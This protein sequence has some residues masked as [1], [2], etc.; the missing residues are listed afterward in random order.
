[1]R[2]GVFAAA[3]CTL[4][5]LSGADRFLS[6]TDL[7]GPRSAAA[8]TSAPSGYDRGQDI[9][10]TYDGWEQNADGT[11]SLYF[12]YFNR[13][14]DEEID[15]P[16]GPNNTFDGGTADR[17]QPTHFYPNRKWWVFMVVVPANWPKEQRVTW[18]LITHGKTNQAKGW[19]QPEW[20]VD[21]DLIAK[22]AARDPS[23]MTNGTNE[24]DLDHENR[25]PVIT[26]SPAQTVN[27][28]DTL[29]LTVTANDDGHPKPIPDPT[30]HL[31]QGVRVRWI[32][33]RGA[34]KVQFTPDILNQR[35]YGKPAML[36]TKVRF[37]A[38]GAYRLRAIASDGQT[39][40][41]Y[42]VDVT[43]K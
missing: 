23:L 40:S 11:Y 5:V 37:T 30:G 25:P 28:S 22:N 31:Q 3:C 12:G 4:L 20:E 13:N 35:V 15:V 8:Q 19:L 38:P 18:T 39:F 33:Y 6:G 9:S 14:A 16:I 34:G 27:V 17:G 29:A 32:V 26:G 41:T 1:M 43:V 24:T 36:D 10:P 21:K 7:L 2:I 42:D